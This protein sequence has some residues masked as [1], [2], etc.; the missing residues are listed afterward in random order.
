MHLNQLAVRFLHDEAKSADMRPFRAEMR[1]YARIFRDDLTVGERSRLAA[2]RVATRAG[3][4]RLRRGAGV[5]K[6]RLTGSPVATQSAGILTAEAPSARECGDES[7]LDR[8]DDKIILARP[9]GSCWSI[10][11]KARMSTLAK[12]RTL[13]R[14][15]SRRRSAPRRA[16][17]SRRCSGAPR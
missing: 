3:Y 6:R 8:V 2:R 10:P 5:L 4:V 14:C 16:S 12:R 17:Q 9:S 15:G 13:A 1:R 7:R 11:T